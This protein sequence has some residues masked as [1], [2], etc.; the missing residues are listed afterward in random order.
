MPNYNLHQHSI[1]SDGKE[2][3]NKYVEK[4]IELNFSAIGFTEHS[5]LPFETPFSLKEENIQ[6]YIDEIDSLKEK[7]SDKLEIYR[8]LEM[9]FVPIFSEDF[10]HWKSKC[11]T[12]YLIG[13]VHLVSSSKENPLWFTDGP[14][15]DIYDQGLMEFF[16]G[17]IKKAVKTFYNQTNQ[18]IETQD[19]DIIGHFDKIK[20]HN[21]NRFFTDE[22]VWYRKL[23]DETVELIKEKGLIVEINTRGLYK[24]RSDKLFPDDYALKSVK[25]KNIPIIISS[26]AHKA[27]EINNLFPPTVEYLKNLRFTE[28]MEFSDYK[29][30]AIELQ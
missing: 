21:A 30:K 12:D 3:P 23:I 18:M 1:F 6:N 11:K 7:F 5:P 19:F 4:A 10:N 13:S 9:D 16:G 25:E 17:D 22:D 24:K 8:A 2:E 15:P 28:M 14:D 20:M 26:D 27:D 29:W